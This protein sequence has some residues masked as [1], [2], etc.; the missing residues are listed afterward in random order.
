M[1]DDLPATS[2]NCL[3]FVVD[4]CLSEKEINA[5]KEELVGVLKGLPQGMFVGLITFNRY[6][7]VLELSSKINTEY[8][9]NGVKEYNIVEIMGLLGINI[10][11]DPSMKSAD[12]LKRFIIPLRT[13][14]DVNKVITRVKDM[15]KD[16]FIYVN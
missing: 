2:N 1:Q 4:L 9:I 3:L 15:K 10:K 16:P 5:V 14:K 12:I 11:A 6:V 8:R 13:E 7:N